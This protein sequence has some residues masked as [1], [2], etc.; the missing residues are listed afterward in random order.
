M[1]QHSALAEELG[2]EPWEEIIP[3]SF[4]GEPQGWGVVV[5]RNGSEVTLPVVMWAACT[6]M[7]RTFGPMVGI[8]DFSS[9]T[10]EMR[11]MVADGSIVHVVRGLR[12]VAPARTSAP[13]PVKTPPAVH[14]KLDEE[15]LRLRLHN[16]LN[17]MRDE[18]LDK[19]T[20]NATD[21][22]LLPA[23]CY[24]IGAFALQIAAVRGYGGL[25]PD[26]VERF[27]GRY[28]PPRSGTPEA[29]TAHTGFWTDIAKVLRQVIATD[30]EKPRSV[31]AHL[32]EKEDHPYVPIERAPLTE[33]IVREL[34]IILFEAAFHHPNVNVGRR[35][36]DALANA[37]KQIEAYLAETNP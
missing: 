21:D 5:E 6:R 1:W 34:R 23:C 22:V 13:A 16:M 9:P 20:V 29:Y 12:L 30:Q 18:L 26:E 15:E 33:T 25:T 31:A 8:G 35:F 24:E 28:E 36:L 3:K 4:W 10:M 7:M 27:L 2:L 17:A 11:P 19:Y 37:V 32:V 14:L